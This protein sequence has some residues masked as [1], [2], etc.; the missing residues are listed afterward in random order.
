MQEAIRRELWP[1]CTKTVSGAEA[2]TNASNLYE[3]SEIS[4]ETKKGR[5]MAPP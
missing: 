5:R 3:I 4:T 2:Y 1:E